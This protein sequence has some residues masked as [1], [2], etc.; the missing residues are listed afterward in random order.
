[1]SSLFT[2]FLLRQIEHSV[3]TIALDAEEVHSSSADAEDRWD[4]ISDSVSILAA[5]L[6]ENLRM[7]IEPTLASRFE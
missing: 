5:E 1:M 7:I 4:R 3:S 2:V 6:S